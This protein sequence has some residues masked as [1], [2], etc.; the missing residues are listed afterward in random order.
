MLPLLCIGVRQ[1]QAKVVAPFSKTRVRPLSQIEKAYDYG[2]PLFEQ[3]RRRYLFSYDTTNAHLVAVNS[4]GHAR[5]L[6]GP[7]VHGV[8][9][10]NSDTLYSSAALDLSDGPVELDV[11]DFGDRYFSVAL[12]DAYTN[13][14]SYVGTRTGNA[15]GGRFLIVGPSWRGA[16][17]DA[18]QI[19]HAP[20]NHPLAFARI[21]IKGPAEYDVV[22][23]LQD[24]LVL[25]PVA[26]NPA[27]P[28][29][30]R[31]ELNNPNSFV[32][33]VNQVLRDDPPPSADG[34]MLK[35][36][37]L[38]GIGPDVGSLS[39]GQSS[40]WAQQFATAQQSLIRRSAKVG[41][42]FQGWQYTPADIGNFGT[43][44]ETRATIALRG[45]WA[46]IPDEIIYTLAGSDRSGQALSGDRSYRLI[47]PAG[48]PP[49]H[50]FWSLAVYSLEA[51]GTMHFSD[52][53]IHRYA[54][55][56]D[57]DGLQRRR[58]GSVDILIQAN[59]PEEG[60][61]AWLPAPKGPFALVMRVYLPGPQLLK[62]R[63]RYPALERLD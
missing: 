1:G 54:I 11:P 53:S 49:M 10:P 32:R 61:V 17:P 4:F 37:A 22:H 2:F 16:V 31:P 47:L 41:P 62:G 28:D 18:V 25:I 27:R 29:L 44:Y 15:H 21:R 24:Q 6:A 59:E 26:P 36:L 48:S 33:T 3:A 38:V 43:D 60:A 56:S 7:A 14:F 55:N 52:N 42:E 39:E 45:L 51:D 30:V 50:G 57:A 19:I 34:P 35:R 12:L 5:T 9:T 23:H 40:L 20:G 46:C 63:F 8:T 58:D 13:N